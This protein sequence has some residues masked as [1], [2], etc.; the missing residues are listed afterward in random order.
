MTRY[1]IVDISTPTSV[2]TMRNNIM[3][4]TRSPLHSLQTEQTQHPH[5]AIPNHVLHSFHHCCCPPWIITLYFYILLVLWSPKLYRIVY[6]RPQQCWG[7]AGQP[8]LL[9]HSLYRAESTPGYSWPFWLS[10]NTH[11]SWWPSHQANLQI[12][13]CRAACQPLVPHSVLIP[14]HPELRCPR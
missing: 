3:S 13:F 8:L 5:P 12:T 4:T 9:T 10:G 1:Q 6:L 2:P 7:L 11:G 14:K